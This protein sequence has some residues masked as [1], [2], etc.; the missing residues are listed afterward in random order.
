MLVV[1]LAG[2]RVALGRLCGG[3][4]GGRNK[5]MGVVVVV[6]GVEVFDPCGRSVSSHCRGGGACDSSRGGCRGALVGLISRDCG[7]RIGRYRARD[8]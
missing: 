2:A 1:K 6:G 8:S 7:G 3:G 5:G 4:G